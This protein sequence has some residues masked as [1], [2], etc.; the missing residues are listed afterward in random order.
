MCV[1]DGLYALYVLNREGVK[2][3]V[4]MFSFMGGY[5]SIVSAK[6]KGIVPC[7]V[8]INKQSM[9]DNGMEVFSLQ[10]PVIG[11]YL[12]KNDSNNGSSLL[13]TAD[14]AQNFEFFKPENIEHQD[15]GG[16]CLKNR[17]FEVVIRPAIQIPAVGNTQCLPLFEH[18]ADVGNYKPQQSTALNSNQKVSIE[19]A[20]VLEPR[21]AI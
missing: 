3:S 1:P 10:L 19:M 14:D 17:S 11:K 20:F 7:F 4:D 12:K 9:N 15:E 2:E 8:Q 5:G 16:N 18:M 6:E 13:F 21:C